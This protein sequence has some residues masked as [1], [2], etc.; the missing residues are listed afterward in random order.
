MFDYKWKIFSDR[1]KNLEE[2]T[3]K[4]AKTVYLYLFIQLVYFTILAV[5]LIIK[6]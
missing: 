3:V 5:A 2:F 1:S 6:H 4:N